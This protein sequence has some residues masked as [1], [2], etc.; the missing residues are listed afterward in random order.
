MCCC[1][2]PTVNGQ[3]LIRMTVDTPAAN[4]RIAGR[5]P[6]LIDGDVLLYDEPGRCGG[7]DA[8]SHHFRLALN[9]G[10]L[11]LLVKHGG[12]EERTRLLPHKK[13][14]LA[15]FE[16]LDSN[17]RYWLLHTIYSAHHDGHREGCQS[18]AAYWRKAAAEKRIKVR[19][20]RGSTA[21]KVTVTD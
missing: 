3:G 14:L 1:E 4:Y 11:V 5:E 18:T 6:S 17:G 13:A 8:H 20:V 10:A 9:Y 21:V 16:S 19:K 12:G 7:L 15:I 2:K